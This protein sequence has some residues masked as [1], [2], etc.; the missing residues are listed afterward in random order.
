MAQ[1]IASVAVLIETLRQHQLLN[2]AELAELQQRRTL[3]PRELAREILRRNWLTAYQV[4]QLL[5]GNVADL[6]VGP[7]LVVE[8]LDE[9]GQGQVFKARHRQMERL[10]ALKVLHKEALSDAEIQARFQREI[11]VISQLDHPNV[12]HAYEAG[13]FGN[14][15]FLALEFVEGVNLWQLVRKQGPLPA[16]LAADYTRQA[17]LGLQHIHERGLVHRDIKPSNLVLT[18]AGSGTGF[19]KILDLGL[20]RRMQPLHG[21]ST[22]KLTTDHS[23]A[24]GTVD[25]MAPEQALDFHQADIRSDIYSLGYTL[26]FLLTG[27][28]PFGNATVAQKLI[29]HQHRE[30][31]P[32]EEFTR[33]VPAH[34]LH[35][36]RRMTAKDPSTRFQCPGEVAAALAAKPASRPLVGVTAPSSRPIISVPPNH[37]P[38]KPPSRPVV[39]VS[40]AP[41]A[42]FAPAGNGTLRP[43][44]KPTIPS[45]RTQRRLVWLGAAAAGL[46]GLVVFSLLAVALFRKKEPPV[47]VRETPGKN[48]DPKTTP[49]D[50]PPPEKAPPDDPR[51]FASGIALLNVERNQLP[52]DTGT[53]TRWVSLEDHPVLG[54]ALKASFPPNDSFGDRVPPTLSDWTTY[55]GLQFDVFNP[56]KETYVLRLNIVHRKSTNYQTR[57]DRPIHVRPGRNRVKIPIPLLTN[58][59]GTAADVAGV[60]R[61]FVHAE[62]GKTPTLYFGTFWL[63]GG[64]VIIQGKPYVRDVLLDSEKAATSLGSERRANPVKKGDSPSVFLIAFELD[65]FQE[66]LRARTVEKATFSFYVWDPA[67]QGKT[68]V[69]VY[70][71]LSAW[72]ESA[73]TWLQAS[74]GAPWKGK[75]TKAGGANGFELGVD[76]GPPA[77]MV[78]VRPDEPGTDTVD[79]PI[80]YQI[81]VTDLVRNWL[82]KK[83]E[84]HGLALAGE[85]TAAVDQGFQTR[86]QIY[87]SEYDRPQYSPK[88]HIY[89]KR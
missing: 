5:Q 42:S 52:G 89:L 67:N 54:R 26:Y 2:A 81:D 34:V 66:A 19:V 45:S 9:G 36:L 20:A 4:N 71:V 58:V 15:I 64:D 80:E 69:R 16:A 22:E 75:S 14:N 53:N 11:K 31:T 61:W 46:L 18:Q 40:P 6:F 73:A 33:D 55:S 49:P 65:K 86:F 76:T 82:E 56:D 25:Y 79:P 10:A 88:L 85:A 21:E 8:R 30:P 62:G 84:N 68:Q 29:W 3:D 63:V 78:I 24:L 59:N 74:P 1:A 57:V 35:V 39:A 13:R 38:G 87:A 70:P 60:T 7:Y 47:I 48:G 50:K 23:G 32:V 28:A 44:A 43:P 12:V 41:M 37:L 17:A 83:Q 27:S 72:Q 77:G 51:S